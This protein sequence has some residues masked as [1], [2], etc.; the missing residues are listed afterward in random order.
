M[1]VFQPDIV[2]GQ[3]PVTMRK[4]PIPIVPLGD[5]V[6]IE[7]H[8]LPEKTA[9]GLLL[10]QV[11]GEGRAVD[12]RLAL[13]WGEVIATGEG[14]YSQN[15]SKIPVVCNVGD[16]VFMPKVATCPLSPPFVAM[17]ALKG[18]DPKYAETI[19]IVQCQHITGKIT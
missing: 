8:E 3:V 1:S 6:L 4:G 15:G 19:V 14:V 13:Q 12:P 18:V 17:L 9:G 7:L 10:P 5:V 16:V 11:N 2:N